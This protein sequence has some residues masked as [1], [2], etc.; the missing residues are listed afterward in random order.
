MKSRARFLLPLFAVLLFS[1]GAR[2]PVI[3]LR[4]HAEANAQ[5]TSVFANAAQLH[6]PTP[7]KAFLE[8]LP[9][10]T[11]GDVKMIFPFQA[12]D[13]TYGCAFKLDQT[14][15]LHLEVLS[16][17]RR[18]SSLVLFL[19]TKAYTHQ[20][21]DL[22]ID[23]AITDGIIF[24]PRGFTEAEIDDMKKCFKEWTPNK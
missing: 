5:D 23:K 24:I 21:L 17:E 8:K 19:Q 7:R 15:R 1:A 22:V 10:I 2:K 13:G 9:S 3:L 6:Y 4:F 20:V 16:T 12:A 11:E 18:G 14:G